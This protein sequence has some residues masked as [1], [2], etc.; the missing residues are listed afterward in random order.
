[1]TTA[2]LPNWSMFVLSSVV[3]PS[4]HGFSPTTG[5]KVETPETR[6]MNTIQTNL[7]VWVHLSFARGFWIALGF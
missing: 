2:G 6:D 1:M 7:E 5:R 4:L 3:K